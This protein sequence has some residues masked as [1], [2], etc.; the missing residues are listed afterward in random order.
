MSTTWQIGATFTAVEG[1]Q[2]PT[3]ANGCRWF[4]TDDPG[5]SGWRGAPAPRSNPIDREQADGVFD[6]PTTQPGRSISFGG[7]VKAP[8]TVSLL[9]GLDFLS[10][11][12]VADPRSDLLVVTEPH[13]ARQALVRRDAATVADPISDVE[14]QW[15]VV[16]FA[17]DP[18]RY[19][20]TLKQVT[21]TPYSGGVGRTYPL[22]FPR[23][24]GALGSSGILNMTNGGVLTAY[25]TITFNGP[26]VNPALR[27]VGG[28][29]LAFNVSLGAGDQLVV[30]TGQPNRSVLL[31]GASVRYLLTSD[32][33]WWALAKG[34]SQAFFTADSG[35]GSVTVSWRDP[36]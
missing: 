21:S 28:A 10:A 20:T 16:L 17:A 3:D 9:N 36:S 7:R 27:L 26:L 6:G 1:A 11:L 25:P 4:V 33:A 12:L 13:V 24:Y 8:D 23:T 18:A 19:S 14:G 30:T 34:T 5:P 22:T 31:N 29:H 35:S 2:P 15:S 32:S